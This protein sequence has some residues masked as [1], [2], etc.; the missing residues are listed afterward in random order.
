MDRL[1]HEFH[2]DHQRIVDTLLTLRR[3]LCQA[4]R[5]RLRAALDDADRLLGPHCKWEEVFLYPALS[6]LVGEVRVQR[7]MT[8][9][10]GVYRSLRR[11]T[12]LAGLRVW[13]DAERVAAPEHWGLLVEHAT[14]CDALGPYV[15]L[16]PS[17]RLSEC[18]QGLWAL[19][20]SGVRLAEYCR[21]RRVA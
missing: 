7:L 18:A 1:L 5:A 9:H 12:D 6:G 16:L 21:E 4:D 13:S 2:A 20:R 10:D 11:L 19:R 14:N 15:A 3:A 17:Q 8:E